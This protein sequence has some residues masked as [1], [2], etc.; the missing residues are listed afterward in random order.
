MSKIVCPGQD[1]RFWSKSDIFEVACGHCGYA[2]EFF[3]DDAT[4]RCPQCGTRVE[5]PKLSLGCAQWCEHAEKCL[6]FD[7]KTITIEEDKETSLADK[8]IEAVKAEFGGDQK[9][10]THAL[11][12]LEAAQELLRHEDANPRVVVAAALRILE[13]LELDEKTIQHV[14]RI[15]GS[16]H[17]AGDADTPEFRVLWDA[18]WLVNI[19]EECA[20]MGHEELRRFIE[21]TFRTESGRATAAERFLSG[22]AGPPAEKES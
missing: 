18:D 11:L 14:C 12:V 21:R 7:P 8:L 20:G 2:I 1:T 15:V 3:K 4:R 9:R 10:I 19:P 5:N 22:T 16:H 17:S 13:E 6:G